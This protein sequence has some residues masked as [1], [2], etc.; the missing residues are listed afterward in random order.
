M[1]FEMNYSLR[2]VDVV[3]QPPVADN[4]QRLQNT[5]FSVSISSPADGVRGKSPLKQPHLRVSPASL[6][7]ESDNNAVDPDQRRILYVRRATSY[8]RSCRL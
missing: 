8:T 3:L 7:G 2:C 6:L 5:V 1:T 4:A